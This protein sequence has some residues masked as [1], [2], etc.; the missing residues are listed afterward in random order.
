MYNDIE[1]GS[2][3]FLFF[4]CRTARNLRHANITLSLG[5]RPKEAQC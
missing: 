5:E 4:L 2:V 3:V 1:G